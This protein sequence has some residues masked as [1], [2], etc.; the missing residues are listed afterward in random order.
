MTRKL[1]ATIVP[2]LAALAP[3][4]SF[5]QHLPS[6]SRTVYKCTIAGKTAYSDEP[7]RGAGKLEIEPTRGINSISGRKIV[8]ADV[9]REQRRE[10]MAEAIRP[11]TGMDA[12]QF[13]SHGRRQKLKLAERR[14]C[15]AL[16]EAIANAENEE[17]QTKGDVRLAVQ[18]Q[19]FVMRKR[20]RD[21]RC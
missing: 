11:L 4:T 6:P 18:E 16:D 14:E 2:I 7:C 8:G 13:D 12:Q 17:A 21:T 3:A 19:L 5:P 20:F 1:F 15:A 10:T 9:H